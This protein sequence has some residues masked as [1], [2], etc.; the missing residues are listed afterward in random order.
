MNKK[1]KEGICPICG[2]NELEYGSIKEYN[3][4]IAYVVSCRNCECSFEENYNL[5]FIDQD[6]FCNKYG[7]DIEV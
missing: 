3:G 2:S 1:Q 5:I 6:S 7:E 4:Y